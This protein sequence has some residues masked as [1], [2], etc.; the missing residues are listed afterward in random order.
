MLKLVLATMLTVNVTS[1]HWEDGDYNE[2]NAG[3]GIQRDGLTAGYYL[4]SHERGSFYAGMVL[5]RDWRWG[6]YGTML[7]VVTGYG[8]I[9]GTGDVAPLVAP[10]VT[11]GPVRLIQ[12]GNA[13]GLQFVYR[14]GQ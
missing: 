6:E 13:T 9:D 3:L 14:F 4:N 2:R 12:V 10:Y 7:G 5:E 1:H 8:H 11:L